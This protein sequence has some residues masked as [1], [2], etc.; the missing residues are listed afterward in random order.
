MDYEQ[1]S[2]VLGRDYIE[3]FQAAGMEA[4]PSKSLLEQLKPFDRMIIGH[5][6]AG[7]ACSLRRAHDR[8]LCF[9][10]GDD[11][12]EA[13]REALENAKTW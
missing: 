12:I 2:R 11:Q 8:Q 10:R 3:I 7:F 4:A 6:G 5:L 1:V 13:I 9:G